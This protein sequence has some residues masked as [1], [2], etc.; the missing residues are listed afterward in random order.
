MIRRSDL[1]LGRLW[2][3]ARLRLMTRTLRATF[4]TVI[5]PLILLL[6]LDS[7]GGGRVSVPGG[8]VAYAQY[9]T[10]SIAIFALTTATYTGVIFGVA[11]AR[12]Q[13]IFKRVRGTPLPMGIF[14]GSW[15]VSTVLIGL[16]AAALMFVFAVAA[17]G[18][19][20]RLELL[21]AAIVTLV[22]GGLAFTALGF[23]VG[24]FIRRVDTA[25]VIANLTLFPLL[26]V[27]GVFYS[28]ENE[29][30]W[31]RQIA[32]VFPLIHLVRAFTACFSPY[33]TGSGFS[34][35]DLSSLLVWGVAGAFVA[36]RRFSREATDE[37]GGSAGRPAGGLIGRVLAPPNGRGSDRPNPAAGRS[38]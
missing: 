9:I 15:V 7:L 22:L 36:V 33:T 23:A 21:P 28:V 29:P 20:I 32:D 30:D 3:K 6:L 35:G 25:P 27:S 12:E 38:R 17:F 2:L 10:P 13:G 8:T 1:A 11:T 31:L 26:F 18:V 19:D 16:A 5:F 24:S 37:E 14:L 34:S 4:F